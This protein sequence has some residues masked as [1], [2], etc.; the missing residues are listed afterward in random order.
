METTEPTSDARSL[1]VEEALS[2][3]DRAR[4]AT[5]AIVDRVSY[6]NAAV[7]V[8]NIKELR[9]KI[10]E[11]FDPHIARAFQA[12]RALVKEKRDAEA[13]L[14]E[15]EAIIKTA[16]AVFDAQQETIRQEQERKL[17]E[18]ARKDAEARQLAEAAALEAEGRATGDPALL[19]E[20]ERLISE[21]VSTPA[22]FVQPTVPKVA[23][24]SH[25]T[26]WTA[27]V[28]NFGAL[29]AWVAKN[30]DHLHV[31]EPN[32]SALNALARA[33][34]SRLRIDGVVAESTNSVAV[35]RR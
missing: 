4:G 31:L 10:A 26:T 1:I 17:R 6:V 16:L 7:L 25:R 11:T 29:V 24:V 13:P 22:V 20:A 27:R 14:V 33:M 19:A 12:H 2:W 28:T 23:G 15:A 21:P 32:P 34:Q 5:I 18:A 9:D 3:P 35:G 30:P 8:Q